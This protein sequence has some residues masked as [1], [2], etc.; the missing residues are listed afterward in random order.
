ML[1][2]Y[3]ELLKPTLAQVRSFYALQNWYKY[4]LKLTSNFNKHI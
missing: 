1:K 4:I 3:D 2:S